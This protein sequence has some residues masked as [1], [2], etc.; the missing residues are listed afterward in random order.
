M[1]LSQVGLL[2]LSGLVIILI[3]VLIRLYLKVI[4]LGNSFA[5]LEL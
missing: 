1:M 2:V 5:K 4:S 3:F